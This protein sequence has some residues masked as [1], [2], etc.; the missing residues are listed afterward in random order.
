MAPRASTRATRCSRTEVPG[1]KRASPE[2]WR[3]A[4]RCVLSVLGVAPCHTTCPLLACSIALILRPQGA[5][6]MG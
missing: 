2:K 1:S 6:A 5:R 4:D 3:G